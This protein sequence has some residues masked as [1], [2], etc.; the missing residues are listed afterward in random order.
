MQVD[1]SEIARFLGYDLLGSDLQINKVSSI[2]NIS[3]GSMVFAQAFSEEMVLKLEGYSD[4]FLIGTFEY[5][6]KVSCALVVSEDVRLDFAKASNRFFS[7]QVQSGISPSATIAESAVLGQNVFVGQNCSIGE[8]VH[9]GDHTKIFSGVV[10]SDNCRIGSNTLIKSNSVIGQDGFSFQR[11]E[12][13]T[14]IRIPHFGSVV[15]GD[16]VEI[17]ALSVV[18]RGTID[19]TVVGDHVKIDDHVFI[20]HNVQIGR[21][22]YVIAGT[23]ISGSVKIG[24]NVWISPNSTVI[25]YVEIGDNSMVGIGSVVVKSVD[26]NTTVFGNPAKFLGRR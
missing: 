3:L 20:A 11:E 1:A 22:S 5:V 10:I 7:N 18:A 15:I 8:N 2:N 19:N 17:G 6:G 24:E 23:T 26:S 9:I 16:F 14:P 12:D 4:I 25:H 21:N 13:G